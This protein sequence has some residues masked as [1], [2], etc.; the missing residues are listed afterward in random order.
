MSLTVRRKGGG[1]GG[2]FKFHKLGVVFLRLL[3]NDNQKLC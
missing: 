2:G 1:R 3:S